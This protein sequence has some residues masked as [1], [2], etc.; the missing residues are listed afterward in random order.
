MLDCVPTLDS[1]QVW[2]RDASRV[3]PTH[4]ETQDGSSQISKLLVLILEREVG[5]LPGQETP[6]EDTDTSD[7]SMDYSFTEEEDDVN[8]NLALA[9][10]LKV[11]QL[12]SSS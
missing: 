5:S 8:R 12:P 7:G 4:A 10:L 11:P 2:M 9:A 1:L 3:Q 6:Q